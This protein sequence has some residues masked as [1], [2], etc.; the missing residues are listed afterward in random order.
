MLASSPPLKLLLVEDDVDIAAGI[1]DYLAAHAVQV[2]FAYTAAQARARVLAERFDVLVLDINLPDQDGLALCHAL[3][4]ECGLQSPVLFLTARGELDDKL[5][6]FA[7]GAVDYV[8]KPFAPAELLARV[9][10]IAA[11]VPATGGAQLRVDGYTLDLHGQLLRCGERRLQ[12][13][14]AGFA[15]LRRLMQASPASVGK[16]ELCELLWADEPPD[17]D[18]LRTHVYHLRQALDRCF[19]QPL[20]DTVRGVGYRFLADTAGDHDEP[21]AQP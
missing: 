12:L 1:G 7:V 17:S 14:P 19:G 10:A 18:P 16:S 21:P 9:R 15:I 8:I 4:H 11:H 3:K 5:H 20:I 6:A 2:D 13:H